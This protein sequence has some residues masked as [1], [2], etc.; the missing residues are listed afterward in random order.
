M[1]MECGE[2][3]FFYQPIF[4]ILNCCDAELRKTDI[5]FFYIKNMIMTFLDHQLLVIL[6]F[7]GMHISNIYGRC[8]N[9]Q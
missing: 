2:I 4:L 6:N 8:Q 1:Q 3:L 9:P 7:Y 5:I